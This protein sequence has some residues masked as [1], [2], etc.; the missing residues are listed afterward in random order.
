MRIFRLILA[1]C[2][3][4]LAVCVLLWLLRVPRYYQA[5]EHQATEPAHGDAVPLHLGLIPERDI[6]TQRQRHL[7]LADYLARY[8][9]RPVVLVTAVSYQGMSDDFA[10]G[11]ID[12]AFVG[13]FVATLVMD[14]YGGQVLVKPELPGGIS[15][16]HGVIF[17]PAESEIQTIE[18]LKG[19]RLAM[20]RTTTAGD[21]FPR[22]QLLSRSLWSSVEPR[23]TWFGTHDDAIAEVLAGRADAG[24]AKD[25]RLTEVENDLHRQ[26]RGLRHIATSK[27]VPENAL[28]ARREV[29]DELRRTLQPLLLQMNSQ[30]DG[31]ATLEKFGAVRFLACEAGE[32][33]AVHEM[34]EQ[35]G[36]AWDQINVRPAASQPR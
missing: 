8:L 15:T 33:A 32:Y 12:A 14:R 2:L 4:A 36:P 19:C 3:T 17:V 31:R 6:F 20:V 7:A 26:G 9:H 29:A 18:D 22:C 35:L 11:R 30:A 25:N 27:A 5:Q 34:I 23:V 1:I 10:E 28:V 21:L 24:A 16:Y 13:S